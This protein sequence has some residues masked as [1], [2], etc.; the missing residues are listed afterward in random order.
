MQLSPLL[1]ERNP[2]Y[3]W[4][5]YDLDIMS[6]YL[7]SFIDFLYTENQPANTMEEK[8]AKRTAEILR[9]YFV[10]QRLNFGEYW[11]DNFHVVIPSTHNLYHVFL[12]VS[13][14]YY[15]TLKIPRYLDYQYQNFKGNYYA[16]K[17]ESF[18]SLIEFHVYNWI[19]DKHPENPAPVLRQINKWLDLNKPLLLKNPAPL[20]TFI[21]IA[22]DEHRKNVV[23]IFTKYF[24]AED[25][26]KL[27]HLLCG[28]PI[29]G[30]LI[31]KGEVNKLFDAFKRLSTNKIISGSKRLIER[32]LSNFFSYK[33]NNILKL[34]ISSGHAHRLISH[35]EISCE[36]PISEFDS[37]LP[38]EHFYS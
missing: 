10:D 26:I 18:V 11:R 8:L 6:I 36:Q 7:P 27:D 30:K 13:L 9:F 31:F 28:K 4:E 35:R 22:N 12:Q 20:S 32:W 3:T 21:K 37:W 38:D 14:C 2:K 17:Q 24:S 25:L 15:D 33:S 29:I 23:D 16:E 5:Q 34:K 1:S 19:K